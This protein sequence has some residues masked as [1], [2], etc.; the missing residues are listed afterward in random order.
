MHK[1]EG[2][3]SKSLTYTSDTNPFLLM[4][5]AFEKTGNGKLPSLLLILTLCYEKSSLLKRLL[6]VFGC[7]ILINPS[8]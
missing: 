4:Y 7:S 1:N 6:W 2:T 8:K 3:Y 5:G